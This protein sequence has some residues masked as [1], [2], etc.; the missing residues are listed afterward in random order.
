MRYH[1]IAMRRWVLAFLLAAGALALA[2]F[3]L[4]L[5]DGSYH[6][7]TE[8][9]VLPDRVRYYS[10]E[11]SDWEEIPTELV[12]LKR[13]EAELKAKAAEEKKAAAE[14]EAEDAF[15]REQKR[16]IALVPAEPGLYQVSGQ[17]LRT[18]PLAEVKVAND[19]RRSILKVLSPVPVVAGKQTVELDGEHS[20]EIVEDP[21]PSFYFRQGSPGL[22]AMVRCSAKKKGVRIVETWNFVPVSKELIQ[23]RDAIELFQ[24]QLGP[25]L[26]RLWPV[27]PVEPGE[28]AVI[29]YTPGEP[30]TQVWDFRVK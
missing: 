8:Y 27:Q 1:L 12:D 5:K 4:Y 16:E 3:R 23:E 29:L 2:P 17:K 22:Y 24:Q 7:V 13:T 6:L 18:F 19:K 21:R 15:E 20:R 11:R 14:T 10:T 30:N 25:N 26:F 9:K 28:Y